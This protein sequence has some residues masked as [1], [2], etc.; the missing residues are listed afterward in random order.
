MAAAAAQACDD[1]LGA[2]IVADKAHAA[3]GVELLAVIGDDAG[4][5]L[6]AMLQRVQA[7]RGQRRRVGMAV[8]AED[9]AFFVEMV[10]V[11]G[12]RS[13]ASADPRAPRSLHRDPVPSRGY[14][15]LLHES[16]LPRQVQPCYRVFLLSADPCRAGRRACSSAPWSWPRFG[17]RSWQGSQGAHGPLRLLRLLAR[18]VRVVG[19][20]G[21]LDAAADRAERR[22]ACRRPLAGTARSSPLDPGRPV[23]R[24]Q[25]DIEHQIGERDEH[26]AARQAEDQPERA[27]DRRQRAPIGTARDIAGDDRQHDQA[28]HE[29]PGPG[30]QIGQQ[31]CRDEPGR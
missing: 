18:P 22:A 7:E 4:R 5:L 11:A 9:A 12:D 3:M 29:Q 26:D 21:A 19:G 14:A 30:D 8:D 15:L 16:A 1:L 17:A 13:S 23:V 24:R 28:D 31:R 27:I 6:A 2:E 20:G 25:A 10:V